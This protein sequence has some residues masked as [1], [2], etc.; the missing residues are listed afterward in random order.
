MIKEEVSKVKGDDRAP[1]EYKNQQLYVIND[2]INQI[3]INNYLNQ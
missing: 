2:Q 1:P 3:V